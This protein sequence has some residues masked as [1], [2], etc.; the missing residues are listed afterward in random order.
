MRQGQDLQY[1]VSQNKWPRTNDPFVNLNANGL[2]SI[3]ADYICDI[4]AHKNHWQF[5][6]S[7]QCASFTSRILF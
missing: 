6:T 3:L 4:L 5:I 2:W 7:F 1:T